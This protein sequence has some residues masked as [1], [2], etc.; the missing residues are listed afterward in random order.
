MREMTDDRMSGTDMQ[1]TQRNRVEAPRLAGSV[2]ARAAARLRR[3]RK[4]VAA[5]EFALVGPVMFMVL[6]GIFVVGVA[7]SNYQILTN[8]AIQGALALSLARG[9]STAYTTALNAINT[10]AGTLNT[11]SITTTMTVAGTSC[12]SSSC[13][14]STAGVVATVTL[15]YPCN[16][17][18][19]GINYAGGT[20]SLTSSSSNVVQ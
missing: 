17:V 15:T 1:Q 4:G 11:G 9:S 18:I 10:A 12:T 8:A 19:Y 16:M 13:S 7:V 5:L 2:V 20:C 3:D 14:V 6:L